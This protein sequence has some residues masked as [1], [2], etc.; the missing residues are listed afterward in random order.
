MAA[1]DRK[2]WSELRAALWP[3]ETAEQHACGLDLLLRGGSYWGFAAE[4]SD[5]AAVG[6]AEVSVRPY[7]N[8]CDSQ[9]VGFLEGIW[10]DPHSADA[11]SAGKFWRMLRRLW[12]RAACVSSGRT[13]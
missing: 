10:V 9:P 12:W 5:G 13:H 4:A 11:V 7:A 3:E 8:G 6:F 2:L 1:A